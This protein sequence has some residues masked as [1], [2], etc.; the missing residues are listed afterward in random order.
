MC[1]EYGSP[2]YDELGEN[3]DIASLP[4]LC[5][6]MLRKVNDEG[7]EKLLC[8]IEQ[9]LTEVLAAMEF[10]GVRVDADGVRTFGDRLSADIKGIEQQIYFMRCDR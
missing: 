4:Q 1:A 5:D 2:Y 7:M 8:E 6:V 3:A 10:Y 9:P